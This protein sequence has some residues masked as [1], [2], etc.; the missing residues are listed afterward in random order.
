MSKR[1]YILT[2]R[3]VFHLVNS[4]FDRCFALQIQNDIARFSRSAHGFYMSDVS[5]ADILLDFCTF[6]YNF[7]K[8]DENLYV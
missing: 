7:L 2:S 1:A 3:D 5:P 8:K 4:M 6:R